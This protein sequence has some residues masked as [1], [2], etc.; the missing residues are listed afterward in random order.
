MHFQIF[1]AGSGE[2]LTYHQ[3]EVEQIYPK[4]GWVEQKPLDLLQT[5]ITCIDKAVENLK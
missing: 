2:L 5:V 1:S 3:E 4:E